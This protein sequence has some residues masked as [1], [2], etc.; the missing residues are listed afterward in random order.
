[1]KSVVGLPPSVAHFVFCQYSFP[2]EEQITVIPSLAT[3]QRVPPGRE[4]ADFTFE[5]IRDLTR[6]AT[7]EFLEVCEEQALSIELYGHR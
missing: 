7:E 4:A 1:M 2:G 6:A 3:G 5:Y